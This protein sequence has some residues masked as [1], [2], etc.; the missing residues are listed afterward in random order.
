V[1]TL[2][3]NATI[4][5]QHILELAPITIAATSADNPTL[6]LSHF[7]RWYSDFYAEPPV[8][9]KFASLYFDWKGRHHFVITFTS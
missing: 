9:L 5:R 1:R 7:I 2:D 3:Q 4:H 6:E 8:R